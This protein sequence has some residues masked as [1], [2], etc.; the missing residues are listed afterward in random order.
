MEEF[1]GAVNGRDLERALSLVDDD[2]VYEDFTFQ[3]PFTGRA[4]VRALLSDAM[5]LPKV[6][7]LVPRSCLLEVFEVDPKFRCIVLKTR[8]SA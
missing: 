3:Q 8:R 5:A 7:V 2:V 4:G 1:Y 6:G